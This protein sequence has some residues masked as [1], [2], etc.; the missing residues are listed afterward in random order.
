MKTRAPVCTIHEDAPVCTRSGRA[1]SSDSGH[2][3]H[4]R[5]AATAAID[6]DGRARTGLEIDSPASRVLHELSRLVAVCLTLLVAL[7]FASE[8]GAQQPILD[9]EY[10]L[11]E[12]PQ[13]PDT[14]KKVQVIEF[15]SYACPHCAEFE[16]AL[17]EW[18]KHKP[19]DVDFKMVPMVFRDAWK[20]PAKLYYT[21]EALDL[22]DKYHQKVYDAIHKENKELFT[23]EQV[24]AWA[25][26][27]GID[28]AKFNDAYDSFGVDA[29]L[30]ASAAMARAYG[31]QFTP[32]MT[33]NGKYYTGPSMVTGPGGG[34][35]YKRF[36]YVVDRLIEMEGVKPSHNRKKRG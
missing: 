8:A 4:V 3:R 27:V 26:S 15:F 7:F 14:D 18:L 6:S 13:K 20:A 2:L 16:P 19:K 1:A 25:K 12:P 21:L 36:F 30:Q 22:V 32:A 5:L 29:K 28:A 11:I 34:L 31:V 17:D 23:D 10:K 24:K 35:D 33:I 9:K